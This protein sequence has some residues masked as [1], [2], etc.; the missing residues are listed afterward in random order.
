[1]DRG[2]Q[3]GAA[4]DEF[5]IR[6][7]LGAAGTDDKEWRRLIEEIAAVRSSRHALLG[8]PTFL[9]DAWL[10]RLAQEARDL[11]AGA[12]PSPHAGKAGQRFASPGPVARRVT[13]HPGWR[14][15]MRRELQGEPRPPYHA[16]YL[17]YDQPG[18]GI[19]PHVDDPEFAINVILMVTRT[20]SGED[21]SA[22]VLHPPGRAPLRTVLQ[23]GEAILL[24]AD[25][26]VHAR[27]PMKRG[28]RATILSMGFSRPDYSPTTA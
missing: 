14:T 19:A 4:I 10:L 24:E 13:A 12:E 2:R 18:A 22:I 17:Y 11:R 5:V 3:L 21:G 1:M 26:L 7:E 25:G 27:E 20:P 6:N 15:L 23:P 8:R 28:E 9:T 16:A